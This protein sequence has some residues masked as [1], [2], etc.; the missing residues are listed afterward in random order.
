MTVGYGG[1]RWRHRE[2]F[3]RDGLA[4]DRRRWPDGSFKVDAARRLPAV[5]FSGK[6]LHSS[7]SATKGFDKGLLRPW[8]EGGFSVFT[9]RS[10][11]G[12]GGPW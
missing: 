4:R 1:L 7:L 8:L 11:P 10:W 5:F 3:E 6:K 9:W 2:S 12:L